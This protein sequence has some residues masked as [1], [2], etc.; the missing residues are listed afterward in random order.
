[1]TGKESY[2]KIMIVLSIFLLLMLCAGAVS[3][4]SD[5]DSIKDCSDDTI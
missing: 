3:A 2:N 4:S 5:A 1:M